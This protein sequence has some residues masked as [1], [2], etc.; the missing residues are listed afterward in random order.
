MLVTVFNSPTLVLDCKTGAH[1][2]ELQKA[3]GWIFGLDVI[4]VLC[5][6]LFNV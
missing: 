6:F 4:E 2:A 3:E 5:L 1:I